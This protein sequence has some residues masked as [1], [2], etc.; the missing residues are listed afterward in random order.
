MTKT[1]TT[2]KVNWDGM[3][4]VQQTFGGIPT[5]ET[6]TIAAKV[7]KTAAQTIQ[8][9]GFIKYHLGST[10][11]GFCMLGAIDHAARQLK[12]DPTLK[13]RVRNLLE[14][15]VEINTGR[16]DIPAYNDAPST[17]AGGVLRLLH[18]AANLLE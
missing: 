4:L 5:C 16:D 8:K 7:L 3:E 11:R 9:Y 12:I 14:E 10:R 1:S 2:T 6:R 17:R 13:D 18:T 15:V